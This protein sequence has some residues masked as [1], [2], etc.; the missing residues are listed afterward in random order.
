M[1]RTRSNPIREAAGFAQ[2][3]S[4]WDQEA[5]YFF[6]LPELDDE[7]E[8]VEWP[9]WVNNDRFEVIAA[10]RAASTVWGVDFHA[11][12]AHREPHEMHVLAVATDFGFPQLIENWDELIRVIVRGYKDPQLV[13][14]VSN[15]SA[16][17]A[18]TIARFLAGDHEFLSRLLDAWNSVEYEPA[19]VR[20]HYDVRWK[21]AQGR[22]RFHAIVSTANE[23]QGLSF[24]DWIPLDAAT[25]VALD[26]AKDATG[27]PARH[28]PLP[29]R[30]N[31]T[32]ARA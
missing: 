31:G 6:S 17:L 12:R 30:T 32:G 2:V 10:N 23:R 16:Y 13:D 11:E 7:V 25:W 8:R 5:T 27:I 28:P 9:Q 15:P 20:W 26:R 22:M 29:A 3:R 19:R 21:H 4:L 14:D 24:N 1:D 18:K